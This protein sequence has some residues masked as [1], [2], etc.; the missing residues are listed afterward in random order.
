MFDTLEYES[1][2]VDCPLCGIQHE[3][4]D[5]IVVH[6]DTHGKPRFR[7]VGSVYCVA[8][9]NNGFTQGE[10]AEEMVR[11]TGNPMSWSNAVNTF[12]RMFNEAGLLSRAGAGKPGDEYVY[13]W[14]V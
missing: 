3:L 4:G 6:E 11:H 9:F 14:N 7:S 1:A 5:F 13:T 8:I 2:M 12:V 10:L